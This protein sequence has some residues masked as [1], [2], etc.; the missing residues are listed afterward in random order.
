M[1]IFYLLL[2][3]SLYA[4]SQFENSN[5]NVIR[6]NNLSLSF[7]RSVTFC[8]DEKTPS[9]WLNT[10]LIER[11]DSTYFV[12]FNTYT[13]ELNYFDYYSGKQVKRLDTSIR[14]LDGI[15][16]LNQD[17]MYIQDYRHSCFYRL[18]ASGKSCDTIKIS[19]LQDGCPPSTVSVFNGVYT[20]D[21]FLYLSCCSLGEGDDGDRYCCM[22]YDTKKK[23]IS[24]FLK[25]PDIY[26]KVNWGG[27]L[28]RL[29]YTCY[30]RYNKRI[31]FSFPASHE[32]SVLDLATD[33]ISSHYAGSQY[34]DKVLPYSQNKYEEV[35]DTE[36]FNYYLKNNSY[37]AICFDKYRNLFYRIA[38]IPIK[39]ITE[40]MRMKQVSIVILNSDFKIVGETLLPYKYGTTILVSPDGLLIPYIDKAGTDEPMNYHLFKITS[41]AKK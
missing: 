8:P 37:A 22:K 2:L 31:V 41:Y 25:Y 36:S 23:T 7:V 28:Y 20:M 12:L 27:A 14:R 39:G 29:I 35:D 16:F 34:I 38:E 4:C 19:L 6:D 24:Y 15:S 11:A 26:Q 5:H 13:G 3:L 40:Q 9:D 10:C 32:L 21:D 33:L 1:R 18:D 17:T 30:D